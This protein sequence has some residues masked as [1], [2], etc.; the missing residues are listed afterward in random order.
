MSAR[1]PE[2]LSRGKLTWSADAIRLL[3]PNA[4]KLS[5]LLRKLPVNDD[6][7]A[8]VAAGYGWVD[9]GGLYS[10][11]KAED[12]R[13]YGGW[14]IISAVLKFFCSNRHLGARYFIVGLEGAGHSAT[15]RGKEGID[16]SIVY[17]PFSAKGEASERLCVRGY[18]WAEFRSSVSLGTISIIRCSRGKFR[19]C[20]WAYTDPIDLC[21]AEFEGP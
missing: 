5:L 15:G 10:T 9:A 19:A 17:V 18:Y 13:F 20:F 3:F 7:E 8:V 12:G 4:L 21:D 14:E 16:P 6:S 11:F 1:Y 2:M